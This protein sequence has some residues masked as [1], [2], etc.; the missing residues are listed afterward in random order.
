ML[1]EV[2][3]RIVSSLTKKINVLREPNLTLDVPLVSG[4]HVGAPQTGSNMASPY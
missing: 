2:L 1:R 3:I 4:R